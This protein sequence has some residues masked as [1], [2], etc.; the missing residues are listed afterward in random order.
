MDY[1]FGPKST[2]H[3]SVAVSAAAPPSAVGLLGSVVHHRG[4]MDVA[5][6]MSVVPRG[7]GPQHETAPE[8]H[9]DDEDSAGG[10]DDRRRDPMQSRGSIR[11]VRSRQRFRWARF[12][13]ALCRSLRFG[14]GFGLVLRCFSHDNQRG[15]Q[16]K[17]TTMRS[18]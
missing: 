18:L 8:D 15:P 10:S 11:S 17:A 2:A 9:C 13:T 14:N 4:A 3:R 5:A 1:G 16:T 6:A 12:G 7:A